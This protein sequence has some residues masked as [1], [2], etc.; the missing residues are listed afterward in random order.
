MLVVCLSDCLCTGRLLYRLSALAVSQIDCAE[1][2]F[3]DCVRRE[4]AS[5]IVCAGSLLYR[6]SVLGVCY[7][8]CLSEESALQTVLGVCFTDFL[9]WLFR[10]LCWE[11][12]SQIVC[13]GSLLHILSVLAVS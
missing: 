3:R 4:T 1:S 7:T 9:C 13:A 12:A 11:F 5:Q 6:L 2:R 8:D 10:R